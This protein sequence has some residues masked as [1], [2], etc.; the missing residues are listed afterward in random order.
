MDKYI[1][2]NLRIQ[3]FVPLK[4]LEPPT[5]VCDSAPNILKDSSRFPCQ[6]RYISYKCGVIFSILPLKNRSLYS[7]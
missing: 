6:R 7:I 1:Q 4:Y 5:E 2:L 3:M